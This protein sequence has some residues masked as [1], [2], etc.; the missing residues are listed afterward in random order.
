MVTALEGNSP[1]DIP[2]YSSQYVR[3]NMAGAPF[4]VIEAQRMLTTMPGRGVN[5]E[6]RR[7]ERWANVASPC[8]QYTPVVKY[9]AAQSA[10]PPSPFRAGRER[11]TVGKG[12]SAAARTAR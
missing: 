2:S 9:R 7:E 5:V 1:D 8:Q 6:G 4:R 12:D 11:R 10:P 3:N